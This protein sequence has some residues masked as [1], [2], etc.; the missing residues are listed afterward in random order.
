MNRRVI[1]R[2]NQASSNC[3]Q[4]DFFGGN[5]P[6]SRKDFCNFREAPE[7]PAVFGSLLRGVYS[8]N[9]LVTGRPQK[10]SGTGTPSSQSAVAAVSY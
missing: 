3:P 8:R 7:Y 10:L 1:L 2:T 5:A 6:S 9:A 4:T